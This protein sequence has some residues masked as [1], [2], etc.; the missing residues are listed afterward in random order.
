MPFRHTGTM[1]P[2]LLGRAAAMAAAGAALVPAA[3]AAAA[4]FGQR[5]L[6]QGDSGRDVRE[7][8]RLLTEVGVRTQADGAFGPRTTRS[9]RR[10]ERRE[11][12]RVDGVVP[13][14]EARGLSRRAGRGA[15]PAERP[16]A[17]PRATSRSDPRDAFPV[18][19][20]HDYGT[21]TNRFGARGGRHQGQDVLA[22]CGVPLVAVRTS[23][24]QRVTWHS[25]GGNYVVLDVDGSGQDHVYMHMQRVAVA[26]GD[27]VT[28]G[29]R[30]G[31]VGQTGNATTCHLHFELWSSPGYY[32]GGSPQDP[33][34]LLRELDR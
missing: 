26:Q 18:Q 33:L 12:L 8:Q 25:A 28:A 24:V 14:G 4:Q 9:V 31:T 22:R 32:E 27:H 11:H 5:T 6:R 13:R 7:L 34:P 21:E 17:K 20:P 29:Q 10:Y 2:R 23:K 3:P 15:Q 16:A 30:I 1:T 19:G